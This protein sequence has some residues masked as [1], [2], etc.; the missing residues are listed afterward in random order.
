[1]YDNPGPNTDCNTQSSRT[2]SAFAIGTPVLPWCNSRRV[3]CCDRACSG[4]GEDARGSDVVLVMLRALAKTPVAESEAGTAQE[5]FVDE[6]SPTVSSVKP[7]SLSFLR[8]ARYGV[9]ILDW[10]RNSSRGR[11]TG[12]S[13]GERRVLAVHTSGE[14]KQRRFQSHRC[15]Y[16]AQPVE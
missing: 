5:P 12:R 16:R 6:E 11:N 8:R 15:R 4:A 14:R 1:M 7:R 10:R 9:L 2:P 13:K 3:H